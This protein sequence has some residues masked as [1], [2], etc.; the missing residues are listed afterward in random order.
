VAQRTLIYPSKEIEPMPLVLKDESLRVK[1]LGSL[2]QALADG[3][4]LT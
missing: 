4:K 3:V 1:W 2:G